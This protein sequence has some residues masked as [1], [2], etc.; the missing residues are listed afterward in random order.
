[1]NG[2]DAVD[3]TRGEPRL[4]V[5]RCDRCGA[6]WYLRREHCPRCGG[7]DTTSSPAGGGG[8]CV[9]VTR[10]HVTSDGSGPLGLTL[11][12]LDEGPTVMG[13]VHDD[14]LSPG[15]RARVDFVPDP[16]DADQQT[17]GPRPRLLPSFAREGSR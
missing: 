16:R 13:R 10:V 15:N 8:L 7:R 17:R 4:V 2:A 3:W 1:V 5:V 9:A 12:E 6:A 14:A 11:V